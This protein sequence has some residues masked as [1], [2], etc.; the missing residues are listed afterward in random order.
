MAEADGKLPAGA[1]FEPE[2]LAQWWA[3]KLDFDRYITPDPVLIQALTVMAV[4]GSCGRSPELTWL[5]P[6]HVMLVMSSA[7]VRPPVMTWNA[8]VLPLFVKKLRTENDSAW[9]QSV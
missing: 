2:S 6:S 4:L 9:S 3:T 7:T 1:H 5:C 8:P